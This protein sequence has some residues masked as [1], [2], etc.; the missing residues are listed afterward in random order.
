[1]LSL[2]SLNTQ[3]WVTLGSTVQ[4]TLA[5]CYWALSPFPP[6]CH[7]FTD[8]LQNLASSFSRT[9]GS[10]HRKFRGWCVADEF[11]H[12]LI[13]KS[14]R[15]KPYSAGVGVSNSLP[16]GA[17]RVLRSWNRFGTRTQ[18]VRTS[19]ALRDCSATSV[20][21]TEDVLECTRG[22]AATLGFSGSPGIEGPLRMRVYK[23][24]WGWAVA[25][26]T[27][28]GLQ[29]LGSEDCQPRLE[30]LDVF[31][32]LGIIDQNEIK[33]LAPISVDIS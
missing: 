23:Q 22:L 31:S 13:D 30:R 24:N 17:W 8:P 29:W 12:L 26:Y 3:F 27:C 14:V 25:T 5:F 9:M 7:S 16:F 1:M 19:V 10:A 33:W 21:K 18:V 28:H 11:G 15:T 4:Q 32:T 2:D 6:W 20:N